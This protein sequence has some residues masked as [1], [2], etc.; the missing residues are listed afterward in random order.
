MISHSAFRVAC[1]YCNGVNG[2]VKYFERVDSVERC[3]GCKRTEQG[4]EQALAEHLRHDFPTRGTLG[5][6]PFSE[7]YA[8]V[9]PNVG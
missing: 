3:E 9:E 7:P 2:E 1:R 5:R 6:H 8:G 4:A